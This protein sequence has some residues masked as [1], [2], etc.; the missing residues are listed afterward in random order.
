MVVVDDVG[1]NN[2]PW[3][4]KDLEAYMP[5]SKNLSAQ[6]V[7]L[8]RHYAYLYCSPSRSSLLSGRLPFHVNQV[9]LKPEYASSGIPEE[10]ATIPEKLKSAGYVTH[11]TGK[12]HCGAATPR[13]TPH[14]RGFDTHLG[15]FDGAEDHFTQRQCIDAEC[16]QPD[17]ITSNFI[18]LWH[19]D[20][21]AYGMNGTYG[22]SMY[23]NFV[24]E[25]LEEHPLEKPVFLYVAFQG[26]HAPLQAPEEYL[27]KFPQEWA[28]DRR[29]YA[30]MGAFWDM[31]L[32]RIVGTLQRRGM[33]EHTLLVLTSDNGGPVYPSSAP[34]YPHCGGANNWPLLGGKANNFEG[35][36]RT[37]AFAS[38]GFLPHSV[39]GTKL[40]G[41]IHIG[42]WYATLC[43]LAGVNPF[44]A[45][46]AK[47]GLPAV[48]SINM[49]PLLSG[50]TQVSPRNEI[51]LSVDGP[52]FHQK[53][54]KSADTVSALIVGDYKLLGGIYVGTFRQAPQWPTKDSCCHSSCFLKPSFFQRCGTASKPKCLY[55]IRQDPEETVNLFEAEPALVRNMTSRLEALRQSLFFPQLHDKKNSTAYSIWQSRY[56]GWVG[57][58]KD[59]D[60]AE[61]LI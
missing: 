46:A 18:D 52:G 21:P 11:A 10:M 35:G 24:I 32:G 26:N 20:R 50:S 54:G 58:W 6:G 59:L 47:A 48:D 7:E 12:W 2:V 16:A 61:I 15:Y 25:T 27:S 39:R 22:D 28:H 30:A 17:N 3:H 60:P 31:A 42:D 36:V 19:T 37:A 45:R 29:A 43:D 55:N 51:P 57:P 38:G 4:N 5:V 9:N 8:D 14:G 41:Y 56:R 40:E 23:A 53:P 44:D 33:W 13:H 1:W 49:W 34:R